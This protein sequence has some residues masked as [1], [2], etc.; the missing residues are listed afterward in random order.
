M[1]QRLITFQVAGKFQEG[2]AEGKRSPV[3]NR[4]L[5]GMAGIEQHLIKNQHLP[6]CP[7]DTAAGLFLVCLQDSSIQVGISL[8]KLFALGSSKLAGKPGIRRDL[9][10]VSSGGRFLLDMVQVE[11]ELKQLRRCAQ[12]TL[13]L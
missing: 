9:S 2:T 13:G 12:D 7:P 8:G 4:C 6:R 11:E 1:L 3:G 5:E 10:R